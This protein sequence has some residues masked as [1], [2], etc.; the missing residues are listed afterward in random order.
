M[1]KIKELTLR[2]FY[3]SP[4]CW[5]NFFRISKHSELPWFLDVSIRKLEH[6]HYIQ[7]TKNN[8]YDDDFECNSRLEKKSIAS[9][10][11]TLRDNS[12]GTLLLL[13][14]QFKRELLKNHK[15][16]YRTQII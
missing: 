15:F 10:E 14:I 3:F 9:F 12:K 2:H 6:H 1:K 13:Q 7:T 8:H 4:L 11:C 5:P 16:H